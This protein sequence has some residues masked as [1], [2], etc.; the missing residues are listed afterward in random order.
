[1]SSDNK[2]QRT[3]DNVEEKNEPAHVRI[4]VEGLCKIMGGVK[5]CREEELTRDVLLEFLKSQGAIKE[6]KG[7]WR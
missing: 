7:W 2:R 5:F 4:V 3:E 1:M 6:V